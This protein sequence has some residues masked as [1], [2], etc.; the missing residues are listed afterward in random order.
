M[1]MHT[2]VMRASDEPDVE[3]LFRDSWQVLSAIGPYYTVWR[4]GEEMLL[5]WKAGRWIRLGGGGFDGS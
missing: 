4:D 1:I 2:D 5:V 3:Q